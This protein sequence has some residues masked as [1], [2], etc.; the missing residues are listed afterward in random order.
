MDVHGAIRSLTGN[1]D[2]C[3]A[4]SGL[5]VALVRLCHD[6]PTLRV[7]EGALGAGV[8]PGASGLL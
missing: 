8:P 2:V 4:S 7:A 3:V 1:S 5:L 6:S